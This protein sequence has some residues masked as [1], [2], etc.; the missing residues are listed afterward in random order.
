VDFVAIHGYLRA[1]LRR[2]RECEQ[3]GP[4]LA[5]YDR[6]DA[7]PYL[8][9]AIP[10]DGA[11]ASGDDVARLIDA[12]ER[13]RLKPRLEYLPD[14]APEIEPALLAAGFAV[15]GRLALM[16]YAPGTGVP[17]APAGMEILFPASDADL[18]GVRIVQAEADGEAE[19]PGD[20][21]VDSLRRGLDA[22]GGAILARTTDGHSP[23]GAGEYTPPVNGVAEITSVGVRPGYRRRGIA[24]AVT[25]QLAERALASSVTTLFLMADEAEERIYA[26]SGFATEGRILHISR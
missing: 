23:A 17:E 8:N 1:S 11:R 14:L 19:P 13:R 20:D 16:G 12:Y 25:A 2:W 5:S 18:L 6:A 15:E 22:G 26:R 21:K 4:F 3:I 10:D 7:N 24:A 9:Y